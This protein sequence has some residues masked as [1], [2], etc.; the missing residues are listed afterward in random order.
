MVCD[1]CMFVCC[2]FALWHATCEY[3]CGACAL[4]IGEVVVMCCVINVYTWHV[5]IHCDCM[6]MMR[7]MRWILNLTKSGYHM[8]T[9]EALARQLVDMGCR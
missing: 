2:M 6:D 4:G 7:F 1:A 5:L 9:I 8:L 3:I